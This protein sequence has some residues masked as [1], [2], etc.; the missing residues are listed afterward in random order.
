MRGAGKASSRLAPSGRSGVP[1]TGKPQDLPA[2]VWL[3]ASWT[4]S[5]ESSW[6]STAGGDDTRAI[7]VPAQSVPNLGP[8]RVPCSSDLS[9]SPKSCQGNHWHSLS[10]LAWPPTC[11]WALHSGHQVGGSAEQALHRVARR[12][13]CAGGR[14]QDPKLVPERGGPGRAQAY[15]GQAWPGGSVPRGGGQEAGG[16]VAGQAGRRWQQRP[17]CL[18]DDIGAVWRP[19]ASGPARVG[20]SV[21]QSPGAGGQPLLSATGAM[22][23][24][25]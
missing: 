5:G 21:A 3:Y 9:L 16:P 12:S 1:Q 2:W 17:G 4:G 7:S 15:L 23:A 22:P 19:G 18:G 14:Q 25:W 11:P 24:A 8:H 10:A 20:R 6:Q 13:R